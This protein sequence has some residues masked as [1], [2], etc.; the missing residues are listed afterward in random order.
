MGEE[1]PS[2]YTLCAI[3]ALG[4][5]AMLKLWRQGHQEVE[6]EALGLLPALY[7]ANRIFARLLDEGR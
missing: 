3:D 5:S 4:I 6:G 1:M 7:V 2:I